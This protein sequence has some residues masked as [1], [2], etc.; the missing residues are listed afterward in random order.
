MTEHVLI[1]PLGF[2]AGAVSGVYFAL[3][4]QRN[5]SVKKVIT[6][7]TSHD[8][9][10]KAAGI[11]ERLFH[12][13][14]DVDYKPCYIDA[15]DLEGDEKDASG[16]FAA[17]MGLYIDQARRAKQTV[18]VAVTGGR[19]GMGALA[20]LAAQLYR[21][22]HLYHLWVNEEIELHGI[23]RAEPG[24]YNKYVNPTIEPGL[25]EL[26]TLPLTNLSKLVETVRRSP[27]ELPEQWVDLLAEKAPIALD[28]LIGYVPPGLSLRS[29][30]ELLG[31]GEQWSIHGEKSPERQSDVYYHYEVGLHQLQSRMERSHPR[32]IELLTY[33]QRLEENIRQARLY[34]D[35][36]TR[37][38]ERS[39]IIHRFNELALSVLNA[40]FNDLCDSVS[41]L[42]QERI[43]LRTVSILYSAGAMGDAGH[44]SLRRSR[45]EDVADSYGQRALKKASQEDDLG[46][47]K[48]LTGNK[49]ALATLGKLTETGATVGTFVLKG[50]ELWLKSQGM[51]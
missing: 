46:F 31:L 30:R 27:T 47:F 25:C 32:Y 8:D 43:W 16:P 11:L 41:L 19:S 6:V 45:D 35:T 13:V 37:S 23:A 39:E 51:M 15:L 14:G 9:V 42:S 17:R 7:G 33:Q 40:P 21:A 1:S 12:H 49:D 10:R 34:G 4:K 2:A 20:A 28:T 5:V 48:W 38:A 22:N 44:R 3:E 50:I 18:H 36:P 26:V 29:A 24:L